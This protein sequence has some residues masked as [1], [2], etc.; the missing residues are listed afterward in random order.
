MLNFEFPDILPVEE[1]LI[2]NALK[3][4]MKINKVKN[5]KVKNMKIEIEN[6]PSDIEKTKEINNLIKSKGFN[7]T[8][9]IHMI[10][11]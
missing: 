2:G 7:S 8:V 3:M 6:L 10:I 1:A 11:Y 4:K 5:V 9:S